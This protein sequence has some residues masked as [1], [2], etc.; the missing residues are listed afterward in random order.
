MNKP[1]S[2]NSKSYDGYYKY[3][4]TVAENYEESRNIERHWIR[5]NEFIN[6]YL[7]GNHSYASL[8]DLP[9]GTGRFLE[10]YSYFETVVGIDISEDMLSEARKKARHFSS[11]GTV[12]LL[13]GDVFDIKFPN[14]FFDISI[15]FR[16]FHLL[17]DDFLGPAIKELCR[18]THKELVVQTYVPLNN[19]ISPSEKLRR[20]LTGLLER[21]RPRASQSTIIATEQPWLHIQSYT[22]HQVL[23][24]S[25]FQEEGF[26]PRQSKLLD[27]Y[28][29][30]EVRATIYARKD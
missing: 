24:D 11:N 5:E 30:N 25:L 3:D 27:I 10:Y 22:H 20:R 26:Y 9:V 4:Q 7:K 6:N 19:K 17:P 18:V 12:R 1:E 13:K 21:L 16:L 15:I 14:G 28:G 8:L 2:D 23:F 29:S